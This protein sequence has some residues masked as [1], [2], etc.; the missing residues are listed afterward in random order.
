MALASSAGTL[1]LV[2]IFALAMAAFGHWLLRL[3]RISFSSDAEQVLCSIAVAVILFEALLFFAQI[4]GHIPLSVVTIF[5]LMVFLGARDV[6]SVIRAI[7]RIGAR[8]HAGSQLEL[9]LAGLTA[10]VLSLEAFATMAPLTGSDALHYHFTVPLIVLR[11]GFHPNFFLSHS[12]FTGQGHL[13]ILAGLALGSEKLAL[14]FMFFGGALAA[15]AAACLARNWMPRPWAWTVALAFLLTPVV[16]WQISSAGAPDLWMAFFATMGVIVIAASHT[17]PR[18]AVAVLAGALAGA[19]AG[20][21]YTGCFVAASMAVAYLW[22]NRSLFRISWFLTGSVVAGVWPYA[23]NA[24]W[25]GDPIFPFLLPR[26]A[27]AKVNAYALAIDLADTGASAPHSLQRWIEFPFFAGID[28]LHPGFWQFFGPLVLAF[29]PLLILAA[30]ATP[31]WR[32]SLIVWIVSGI[33]IG[34]SSGMMRFLL[35]LLPIGL[36]VALAG[37]AGVE[38]RHWPWARRIS[39]ATICSVLLL[40]AAGLLVYDRP[41]LSVALGFTPRD[42]YLRQR[43]QEYEKIQ[44]I[45]SALANEHDQG[46]ALVFVRH[47][48]YIRVPYISGSPDWNWAVDPAKMQSERDWLAF[49]RKNNVRWIVRSPSYPPAIAAP[50]ARLETEG[51]LVPFAQTEVSDIQGIRASGV[52]QSVPVAIFRVG[53]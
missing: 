18:W 51:Y 31:V 16:F 41:A 11:S 46:S 6:Y 33:G 24:L 29:L 45:N 19:V 39:I 26:L 27:P 30:R 14:G 35:P 13:L 49:F 34:A 15:A 47:L 10:V 37:A 3:A 25:A 52:R 22:E 50:L 4:L 36:A 12:F 21:K 8:V 20:T 42:S 44:F 2:L 1:L 23:R 5:A 9:L 28:H 40:G 17:L 7:S 32:A 43:A 53:R 38:D 48:Y